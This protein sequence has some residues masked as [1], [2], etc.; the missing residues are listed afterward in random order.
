MSSLAREQPTWWCKHWFGGDAESLH[1]IHVHRGVILLFV[2]IVVVVVVL[3]KVATLWTQKQKEGSSVAE[4]AVHRP[5][6]CYAVDDDLHWRG[7]GGRGAHLQSMYC[8]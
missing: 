8:R 1:Q 7:G 5:T 3:C 6:I 2:C 4:K